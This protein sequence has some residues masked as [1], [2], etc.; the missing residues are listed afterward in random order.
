MRTAHRIITAIAICALASVAAWAGVKN[1][2]VTFAQDMTINGTLVRQ[3]TYRLKFD[4]QTGEL[5]IS[6]GSNVIARAT[7]RLE[8]R[9]DKAA[10]TEIRSVR[11]GES[12][13]LRSI[14][15]R[16]EAQRLVLDAGANQAASTQ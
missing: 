11:E 12:R 1:E 13:H 8:P 6:R 2:Q 5:T 4:D 14:S 16:G 9:A 15:F 10:R 7:A 3:G